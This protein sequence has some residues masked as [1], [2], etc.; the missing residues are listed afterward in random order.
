M[1]SQASRK[2]VWLGYA[3]TDVK[4]AVRARLLNTQAC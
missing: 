4:A 1:E 2:L 3:G